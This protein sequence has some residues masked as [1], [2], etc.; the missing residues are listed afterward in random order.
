MGAEYE[1][2]ENFEEAIRW[3]EKSINILNESNIYNEDL[4]YRF[5]HAIE[6]AQ[7]VIY[8]LVLT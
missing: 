8:S 4:V 2:L 5:G 7:K 1:H 6:V 3:Y